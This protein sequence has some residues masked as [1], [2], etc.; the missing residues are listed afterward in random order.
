MSRPATRALSPRPDTPS[1]VWVTRAQPGAGRTAERLAARGFA[2]VVVPLL[3]IQP[4]EVQPD[5]SGI[6]ALVFTSI[7]GVAAFAALSPAPALPV[8]TVGEATARAA[9]DAGFTHVRS[10]DADVVALA[11]LIRHEAEGLSLLHLGAAEPAGDLAGL[12]GD[13]A[14]IAAQP[15]YRAVET[16][17]RA[18]DAWD[19]VLLHSPRAARAL[20]AGLSPDRART[21]IAAAISPAAAEPLRALGFTEIRIAATPDETGL[22]ATL[23][24]SPTTV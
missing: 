23:G 9:R 4:L 8:F 6:Q 12:V 24:K 7:N 14:R 22:I 3:E 1:R 21:R 10:A 19:F 2:P 16:G 17:G 11:A 20:A 18:P 5:L 13:A 15:V